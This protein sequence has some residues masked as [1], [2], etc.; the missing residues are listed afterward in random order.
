MFEFFFKYPFS[1]FAKGSFVLLGSWP[2][3][4]LLLGVLAAAAVLGAFVLRGRKEAKPGIH[5]GRAIVLWLLQSALLAVLL[6]LLWEPAISVTALKPQQNII[7]VVVDDSRSMALKDSGSSREQQARELLDSSLLK[8]LRSRFQVRLYRLGAGAERLDSTAHLNAGEA[9]TQIGKGLRQLADEAATLPIGAIVLLSDGADNSGGVDLDTLSELRR[10]R[11]PVN[12]IG[13]GKPE[14]SKDIELD[15]LNV[16]VKALE[17]SR[18]QA[19]V[20][21]RQNGFSGSKARLNLVGGGAVLASQDVVLKDAPEQVETVEFSAG[22]SGVKNIEARIDP[23]PGEDNRENNRLTSVLDVDN[24]KRRILYVE[25]E[26]RWEYKFIRRALD[27]DPAVE[28]VSMLR[29]TQNKIYRQGLSK[30]NPHELE[31]GFP[32]KPEDL[33]E[34]QGLILGSVEAAFFT[35]QQGQMIKDF[36]DR[37]GGGLL[38]LGGRWA[39]SDGGYNV[40]PYTELLPVQLPERKNTFQRSFV[41]AELTDAGRKSLICRIEA[42]PEKSNQHWEILPYLANY[43]D[44]GT[45]KPGAVV[46]ARVD[47]GG[48]RLPLLITENYGRGRTAV[49]ATGGSWRWR[50]QQPVGDISQETFWRQLLRW[51]AGATPSRVVA[52]TPNARLEDDGKIQLRAEVRSAQY[53][54]ASD[55]E[56]EASVISPNGGSETVALHPEPL[57]PGVY[58]ADWNAAQ[59]GSYVAEITARQGNKQLGKDVLTFR[60]EDGM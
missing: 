45:P 59:T 13:V 28:I 14:I 19:Q 36:V 2:R 54:P 21:I 27:D 60:R 34:Y 47:A 7:A 57:A 1:V 23:L 15:G 33:F 38:A 29:T 56:V 25:G 16:P 35:S 31:E 53:L 12:T 52:S 42:D 5:G 37:R 44:P 55:A 39:L 49:F 22:K 9:S 41:A 24:T 58:A 18:L 3:W 32:S 40:A 4:A 6:L 10:R 48:N 51:V 8:G 20:T 11:L 43:Q 30:S 50:M 26:P 46:L 17:G